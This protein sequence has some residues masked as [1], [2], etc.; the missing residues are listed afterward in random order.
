[1]TIELLM[2]MCCAIILGLIVSEEQSLFG[3]VI[4]PRW[5]VFRSDLGSLLMP[6]PSCMPPW[7][8]LL[9]V[10]TSN[11]TQLAILVPLH[12]LK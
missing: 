8:R 6:A 9:G 12:S 1:M 11:W 4:L 7:E 2:E 3:G 10:H 5:R